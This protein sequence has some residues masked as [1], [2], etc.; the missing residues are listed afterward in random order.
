VI[1]VIRLRILLRFLREIRKGLT[2]LLYCFS[3][4][5]PKEPEE[6]EECGTFF[7]GEDC[8][9]GRYS[10]KNE[11]LMIIFL[12]PICLKDHQRCEFINLM[13][14]RRICPSKC[15]QKSNKIKFSYVRLETQLHLSCLYLAPSKNA[16][17][18]WF[19]SLK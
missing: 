13:K 10:I 11:N 4:C 9:K 6:K 14:T 1:A 16:N 8:K 5:C 15:P 17:K 7:E 12:S 3:L 18:L 2:F 19:L